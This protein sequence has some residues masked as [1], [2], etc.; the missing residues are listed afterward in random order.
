VI[1]PEQGLAAHDAAGLRFDDRLV[2]EMELR[3]PECES[4]FGTEQMLPVRPLFHRRLEDGVT[5]LL[6][7]LG[8]IER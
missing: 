1:P 5:P 4:Q 3:P 6:S 2:D 8:S 7:G